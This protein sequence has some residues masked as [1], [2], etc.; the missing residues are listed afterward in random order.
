MMVLDNIDDSRN[1]RTRNQLKEM[2]LKVRGIFQSS[3][4]IME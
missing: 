1:K 2:V 4:T 3:C